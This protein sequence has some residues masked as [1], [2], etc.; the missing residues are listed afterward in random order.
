MRIWI[1]R[2]SNGQMLTSLM[3]ISAPSVSWNQN[4]RWIHIKTSV[5]CD[6]I[7]PYLHNYSYPCSY[8]CLYGIFCHR[9]CH[10]VVIEK[11]IYRG[12]IKSLIFSNYQIN[13]MYLYHH[14]RRSLRFVEDK[15]GFPLV[16]PQHHHFQRLHWEITNKKIVTNY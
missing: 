16:S 8:F 10:H 5:K 4:K 12:K 2:N 13:S 7:C 6:K 1:Q 3:P 14:N 11:I 9:L 15:I